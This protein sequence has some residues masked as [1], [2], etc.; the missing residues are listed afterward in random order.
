VDRELLQEAAELYAL[1]P[2]EYTQARNARAKELRQERP[3]LAAQVAK[4]P[5]PTAP[6]AAINHVARDDPSEVRA[7]V[8]AGRALRAAQEDAVAGR[9]AGGVGDAT[10]EHRASLDRV[11]GELRR[12]DLSDAVLERATSTLRAASVDPE[13]QPLLER[14]AL[15][16]EEQA[17]GFGLDPSLVPAAATRTPMKTP[18]KEPERPQPRAADEARARREAVKA[19]QK[20]LTEAKRAAREA[21]AERK[22]LER[23]LAAAQKAEAA[24][25]AAV[26]QAEAAVAEARAGPGGG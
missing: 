18:A 12:L 4:L 16:R 23:E 3:E 14:G 13:L 19:T 22:R 11:R 25:G 26:E 6:A 21:A 2:A 24:A 1:A 7:L 10:R 15:A 9:S 17:S 5:K 8:Q 20:R